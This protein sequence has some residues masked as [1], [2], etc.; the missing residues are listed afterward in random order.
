MEPFEY[1]LF[2]LQHYLVEFAVWVVRMG[3]HAVIDI[4]HFPFLEVVPSP[5]DQV[6]IHLK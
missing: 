3:R 1:E 2:D 4:D 5:I 6:V